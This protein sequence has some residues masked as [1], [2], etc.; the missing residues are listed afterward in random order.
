M[1]IIPLCVYL[2]A[3]TWGNKHFRRGD[4]EC[5]TELELIRGL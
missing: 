2:H 4:M 5:T 1:L 3:C